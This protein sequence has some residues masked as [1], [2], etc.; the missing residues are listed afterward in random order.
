MR[1]RFIG[2]QLQV[3]DDQDRRLAKLLAKRGQIIGGHRLGVLTCKIDDGVVKDFRRSLVLSLGHR[4]SGCQVHR[5]RCLAT[6]TRTDQQDGV[7]EIKNGAALLSHKC[8]QSVLF[9]G[10][11]V[12][13]A[14]RTDR[15]SATPSA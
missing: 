14:T 10:D 7:A 3:I 5:D 1:G 6:T 11:E 12:G 2:D 8:D 13:Q 4:L 9:T 15:R